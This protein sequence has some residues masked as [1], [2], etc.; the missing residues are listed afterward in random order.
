[1]NIFDCINSIYIH[2]I[3]ANLMYKICHY[4]GE[5]V[6]ILIV[7]LFLYKTYVLYLTNMKTIDN[8][9]NKIQNDY[10]WKYETKEIPIEKEENKDGKTELES[11]ACD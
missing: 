11:V 2:T 10:M 4:I 7:L 3:Y 5:I 6:F 1:M 9:Q 8:T